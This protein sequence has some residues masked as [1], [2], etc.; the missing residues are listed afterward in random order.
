MNKWLQAD[1][2]SANKIK[3]IALPGVVARSKSNEEVPLN[4]DLIVN[5][6]IPAIECGQAIKQSRKTKP[7]NLLHELPASVNINRPRR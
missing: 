3:T 4:Y 1:A 5:T 6:L 2:H 7:I